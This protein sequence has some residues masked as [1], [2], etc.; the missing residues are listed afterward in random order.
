MKTKTKTHSKT[1]LAPVF[2][3]KKSFQKKLKSH[4]L[5]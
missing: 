3:K 5:V 2:E 4:S 1:E